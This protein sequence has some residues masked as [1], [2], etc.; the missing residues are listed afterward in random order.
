MCLTTE[1]TLDQ[2]R[3]LPFSQL[4]GTPNHSPFG[5]HMRLATPAIK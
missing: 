2:Q 4:G 3:S 1:T 5:P